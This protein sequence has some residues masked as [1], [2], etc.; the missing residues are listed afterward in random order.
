MQKITQMICDT[1]HHGVIDAASDGGIW[2]VA[3][4][5]D[6]ALWLRRTTTDGQSLFLVVRLRGS[7]VLELESTALAAGT[8]W[9]VVLSSEDGGFAADAQPIEVDLSAPSMRF[10]RPGAVALTGR[11][12]GPLR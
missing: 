7:G 2:Y 11:L 12:D 1:E 5:G 10:A 8:G 6:E 4:L 9:T 3:A